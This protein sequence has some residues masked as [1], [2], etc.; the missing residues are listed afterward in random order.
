MTHEH[1]Q[2]IKLVKVYISR[3]NKVVTEYNHI[4]TD[5]Q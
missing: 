4:N 2:I 1:L 3:N 5:K